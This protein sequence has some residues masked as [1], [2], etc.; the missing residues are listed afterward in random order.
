MVYRL[1]NKKYYMDLF[2]DGYLEKFKY[3]PIALV[4][5]KFR[6]VKNILNLSVPRICIKGIF[7][8]GKSN[9]EELR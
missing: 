8:R 7:K 6:D 2:Q 3:D 5:Y 4:I 1:K 9:V